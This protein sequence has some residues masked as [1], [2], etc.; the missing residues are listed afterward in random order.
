LGLGRP[1]S[2]DAMDVL[3]AFAQSPSAEQSSSDAAVIVQFASRQA[4]VPFRH[5]PRPA[6]EASRGTPPKC[7]WGR[8]DWAYF[9]R[10]GLGLAFRVSAI[11]DAEGSVA[12]SPGKEKTWASIFSWW[13]TNFGRLGLCD[14]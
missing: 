9:H 6:P 14:S 2:D 10:P 7:V 3:G 1:P 12:W 11:A 8:G 13:S 5:G 4:D